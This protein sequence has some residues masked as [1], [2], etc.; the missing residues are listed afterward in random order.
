MH[1]LITSNK[2]NINILIVDELFEGL[3]SAG[4]EAAFELIRQKGEEKTVYVIT[5]STIIDGLNTRHITIGS[6]DLG[7]SQILT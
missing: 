3:D 2:S 1:D 5:H 4:I 7:N 6:D